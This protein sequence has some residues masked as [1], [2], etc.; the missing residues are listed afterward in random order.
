MRTHRVLR[1]MIPVLVSVVAAAC[2]DS[3]DG[4]PIDTPI[5]GASSS[6][7]ATTAAPVMTTAAPVMTTAAPVMTTAAPVMTTAAPG[8]SSAPPGMSSAPPGMSSAPPGMSSAPPAMSMTAAMTTPMPSM[9]AT[10]MPPGTRAAGPCDI[11]NAAGTECVAA[12]SMVRALLSTYEGPLYQVRSGSS[13]MNT[14]TGGQ[15]HDIGMTADGFGDKAA[16]DA[17]CAGSLCTISKLYD[18]SGRGNHLTVAKKGLPAGGDRADEDDWET[19]ADDGPISVGGH[20]VYSLYMD[21][22]QGYRQTVKGAGVPR[23]AEPQGIYMLADGTHVGTA[24]CWD[25]GNVTETPTTY[26]EMNT[27]F[28]GTA[29]WGRGAGNGPWF[30]NDFEAGVYAGGSKAGDPGWG[31]LNSSAAQRPANPN[32]PSLAVKYA[33]GYTKT[34]GGAANKWAL[35]MANLQTASEL[36]VAFEGALPAGKGKGNQGAIVLGVGGDNSNNSWGTFYEGAVVAGYPSNAVE[37]EVMQNVK[38]AGYGQ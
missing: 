34:D 16:H 8:M 18:Q 32:N 35:S 9:S 14:G 33:I 28:F 22:Y 3:G 20:D 6:P 29:Y 26:H 4:T 2:A 10:M 7:A 21:Q 23:G 17:A 11:F 36:T 19:V 5:T 24:C 37:N 27:L 15:T 25:F 12:Y 13:V 31:D 1:P 30:M 38:A